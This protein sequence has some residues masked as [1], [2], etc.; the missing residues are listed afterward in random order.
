MNGPHSRLRTAT[1]S[2]GA[3]DSAHTIHFRESAWNQRACSTTSPNANGRN[4]CDRLA[5]PRRG[6]RMGEETSRSLTFHIRVKL[7]RN[8]HL[9]AGFE[10]LVPIS[11]YAM[12][13]NAMPT[14]IL[15][16]WFPR[17]NRT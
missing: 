4:Q 14:L 16:P 6:G 13:A 8:L 3:L 11:N 1:W 10:I 17:G 5:V 2:S 15:I 7:T 9:Y 12:S